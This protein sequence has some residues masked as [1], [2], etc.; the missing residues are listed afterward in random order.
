MQN[1]RNLYCD[2]LVTNSYGKV[3]VYHSRVPISH[4]EW[5]DLADHLNVKIVKTYNIDRGRRNYGRGFRPHRNS[6]SN[7]AESAK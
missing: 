6:N 2:I 3:K 4:V 5:L 1:R 7:N